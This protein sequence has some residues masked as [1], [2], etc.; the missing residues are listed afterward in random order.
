[1]GVSLYWE[2]DTSE[3]TALRVSHKDL[4]NSAGC[5]MEVAGCVMEVGVVHG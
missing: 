1:M 3:Q 4:E 2:I 5:V